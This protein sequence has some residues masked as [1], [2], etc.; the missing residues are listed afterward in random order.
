[1]KV[2]LIAVLAIVSALFIG[3][4]LWRTD[5]FV[6]GDRLSWVEAQ[7]RTQL[8][9]INYSLITELK[10]L[11]RV[12]ATF[13]AENFQKGKLSWT[14][15]KPYYAAAS[16]SI[17]SSGNETHLE[18][19]VLL[20]KENSK[21]ANWNKEF[22][23]SAIGA[24]AKRTSDLKF[25]IKPFQ[26]SQQGRYVALVFLEGNRAYA[27][28]GAGEIFQSVIDSQRGSLSS[29]SVVTETG[30]TAGHSV[31]E[32]LGT[33]MR[34]DPVFK[35]AQQGE[36]SHG[37]S[38]FNLK[39]GELF[40]MFERIPQSNL[41]VLS[42]APLKETM[43][44]RT[45][46]WWQF[47]LLG[48]G[49]LAVGVAAVL[50]VI[51]PTEKRI[52]VMEQQFKTAA[53]KPTAMAVP[54]KSVKADAETI[55]KEKMDASV[56][57]ASALGHEMS[58]PLASILGY[59]QM[60]LAKAPE[61]D[62]VQ[63]AD[64]IIR[65]T[66]AARGVLDKLLSFAGE[67]VKEKNTM[68][69]EGPLVK[70]LKGLDPVFTQKGVKLIKNFQETST[71][72]LHVDAI[73][74]ALTNIFQNSVE[75]MERMANKEIKVD[76]FEDAE[77]VRLSIEDSGEGI[78]GKNV[79]KI[80]DPFFTT[81]SFQNHMGLG[82]SVAFGILKE[83]NAEMNVQ[84]QRGQGTKVQI[85]FKK[86]QTPGILKSPVEVEKEEFT[87][88]AEL[89]KLK[90]GSLAHEEAEKQ[91]VDQQKIHQEV[92]VNAQSPLDI[93]IENLLELP[94]VGEQQVELAEKEKTAETVDTKIVATN[95]EIKPQSNPMSFGDDELTFI[96]G[97]L[98]QE[99]KTIS[100]RTAPEVVSS[101][102][103]A[104][105]L[106]GMDTE[107]T[108]VNLVTPPK[109]AAKSKT[110]KLDTYHVEVRRPGKRL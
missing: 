28:F 55:H 29:F 89:P 79:E 16:F 33:V 100:N 20:T 108:A 78:D 34:D 110:S 80:F 42:S 53:A 8:E 75:A 76:L 106:A 24:I 60:I 74:R 72:D 6:Y 109:M 49:L 12:V 3:A 54:E 65:E 18:P 87:V 14:S 10:S 63:S 105:E 45:G 37:S 52:E 67:E 23:K 19:Q 68:K 26:D 32:Y 39:S 58:G 2:K 9:A 95:K 85:L 5:S 98:E 66:R 93:N 46:L 51:M 41:I 64:S 69:I 40:G 31:P 97:F 103:T 17:S 88:S 104:E 11:Q 91:F 82:L 84:S 36:A 56:R 77:G 99:A 62:I 50:V 61:N 43:K 57:V 35:E 73:I 92:K 15:L 59:S 25:F 4:V 86:N 7:T 94:E 83:H 70:A 102:P 13:D 101:G 107:L 47:L 44:G 30:L 81:R 27:L 22:I 90:N 1:M 21:V 96:D 71:L 48:C 38:T